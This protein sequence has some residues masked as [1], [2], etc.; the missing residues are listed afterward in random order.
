MLVRG[1]AE[2]L[3]D[4]VIWLV[5]GCWCD[6]LQMHTDCELVDPRGHVDSARLRELADIKRNE[7]LDYRSANADGSDMP[8]QN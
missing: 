1:G 6:G 5:G 4:Q 7:G 2:A 3:R 8:V